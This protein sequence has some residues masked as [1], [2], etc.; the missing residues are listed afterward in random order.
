M[1]ELAFDEM[2]S[3]IGFDE[4]D[5]ARVRSLA[6]VV[7]PGITAIADR[8]YEWL[9]LREDA[10][11][12]FTGGEQQVKRQHALL[13]D[14][15]HAVFEGH[16]DATR[17]EK[18]GKVGAA[19]AGTGLPQYYI[20]AGM[21]FIWLQ[22]TQCIRGAGVPGLDEKLQSLHKLLM[23]ELAAMLE[24]YKRSYAEQVRKFEQTAVKE[25]LT[26]AEHLAEIGQ[27][28]ASLAHEIKNPLAGISGAIQI[29]RDAMTPDHP[30]QP[31]VSEILGQIGRL[32]ATV[33]DLLQ[34][35]RPTPPRAT[36][37]NLDEVVTR[38]LR[39]LGKEPT[40]QRIRI[41]YDRTSRRA[42]VYADDAQIEQLLI[43]LLLNAAHASRDGGVI[44]LSVTYNASYVR[45]HVKDEGRGMAPEVLQ[46]AF[47]PFFT[48][49][50]K[51][52]GLGLSICR[53][54]VEAHGGDIELRSELGEGTRVVVTLPPGEPGAER[55]V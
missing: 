17:H 35:A 18:R 11:A 45:L 28:A 36:K 9:L 8:F 7:R 4:A 12:V 30:H 55:K 3:A 16:F 15:L 6:P 26:R 54:I 52:T 19:H 34:Y 42:A 43:N 5:A 40:L 22:L 14:W 1:D 49:K 44:H 48:T 50:A 47:E 25:K 33:K 39:L 21:E 13:C 20:F 32:D 41:K 10:R 29:I 24:W 27:L 2:W 23:L 46:R 37:V 38:V 31:I 51:G 53:R